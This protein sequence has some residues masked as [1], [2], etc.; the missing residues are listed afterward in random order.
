MSVS[1]IARKPVPTPFRSP[2]RSIQRVL[3]KEQ[4]DANLAGRNQVGDA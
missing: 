1:S 4:A 3:R 2:D